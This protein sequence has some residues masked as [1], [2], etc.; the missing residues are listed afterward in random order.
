M[1]TLDPAFTYKLAEG[2]SLVGTDAFTGT[3]TREPGEN[4]GAYPINNT[5]ILSN[6]SNYTLTYTGANLVIDKAHL[7][8]TADP[9]SREY[10][11]CFNSVY[12]NDQRI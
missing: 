11:V 8:V 5:L 7:T 9:A 6:S 2:S 12:C 3:L 4:A 10:G 1:A